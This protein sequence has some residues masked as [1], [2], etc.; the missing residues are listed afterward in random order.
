MNLSPGR[1]RGKNL[2]YMSQTQQFHYAGGHVDELQYAQTLFDCG[3]LQPNKRP[4]AG[5][6]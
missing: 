2:L 6:I 1:L 5:A 3:R 4:Q